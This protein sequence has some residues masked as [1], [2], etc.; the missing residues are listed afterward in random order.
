MEKQALFLTTGTNNF[1]TDSL[2]AHGV[3]EASEGHAMISA[4]KHASERPREDRPLPTLPP[5]LSRLK[6][7]TAVELIKLLLLY[8]CMLP[9]IIKRILSI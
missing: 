7:K 2:K 8:T 5:A 9:C 3:H 4:A 1:Q 6:P